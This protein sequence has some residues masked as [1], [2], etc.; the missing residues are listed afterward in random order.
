MATGMGDAI[1]GLHEGNVWHNKA[2]IV[3]FL[4]KGEYTHEANK[5]SSQGQNK[6]PLAYVLGYK[7]HTG[8][9][10][11]GKAQ[12]YYNTHTYMG[13]RCYAIFVIFNGGRKEEREIER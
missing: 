9:H 11:A 12:A 6:L 7:A 13:R 1:E 10:V 3:A 5:Q 4:G 2:H 8:R